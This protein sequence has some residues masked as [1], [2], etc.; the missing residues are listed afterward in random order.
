MMA[1]YIWNAKFLG[2]R[3]LVQ[4]L[5]NGINTVMYAGLQLV[6]TLALTVP[7]QQKALIQFTDIEYLLKS[8]LKVVAY[9]S[10]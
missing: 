7:L 8:F 10:L 4:Y 6:L 2:C 1:T 3:C 5:N 9:G